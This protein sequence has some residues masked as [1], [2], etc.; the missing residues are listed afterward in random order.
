MLILDSSQSFIFNDYLKFSETNIMD[1]RYESINLYLLFK[2]FVNL[3]FSFKHYI[4]EYIKS[5]GCDIII[6]FIDNNVLYYQLKNLFPQKKIIFIQNGMRTEFFFKKLSK[7]KDLKVDYLLTFSDFYSQ[8]YAQNI[9]GNLITIGSIK[10]NLIE[11][12]DLKKDNSIA[13]ISSCPFSNKNMNI[14]REI[15]IDKNIYFNP[16]K[17]LLPIIAEFCNENNMT[18]KVVARSK[19]T[20]QFNYEKRFYD[21]ILKGYNYNF[22]DSYGFEKIYRI[23]DLSS[24]TVSIYSAFGLEAIARGNR[25]SFFNVRDKATNFESLSLFWTENQLKKKGNFWS[26]EINKSEVYRVLNY[27]LNSSDNEWKNSLKE[28]V[29]LL[30]FYNPKNKILTD[31]LKKI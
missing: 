29:P 30:T 9:E 18:L 10:N 27:S 21:E 13:F 4:E 8:K 17:K 19:A 14:F 28:I 12:K 31:L 2:T 1:T 20:K 23:A 7:L 25:T 26:N 6:S 3:K 15:N 11:K 24:V 5:S 16:E 22:V